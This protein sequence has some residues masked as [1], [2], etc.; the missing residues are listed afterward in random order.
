MRGSVDSVTDTRAVD[1]F[2]GGD[3]A[4]H[5]RVAFG[6]G[7]E[8]ANAGL[9]VLMGSDEF[10]AEFSVLGPA[11]RRELDIQRAELLGNVKPD[12][13]VVPSPK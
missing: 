9:R 13:E 2:H 6:P 1:F 10:Q 7:D 3:R 4:L 12:R 5:D 11:N 8:V